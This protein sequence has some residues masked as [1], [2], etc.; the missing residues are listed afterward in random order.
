MQLRQECEL[1]LRGDWVPVAAE[2]SG[3]VLPLADLRVSVLSFEDDRYLIIDHAGQVADA[4]RW[5]LGAEASPATLDLEGNEGPNAGRRVLAI[6][7]IDGDRLCLGYDME[8]EQRPG[9]WRHEPDQL[10]LC[11]TYLRRR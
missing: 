8:R 4:G 11:I 2:V 3:Q 9:S 1:A 5:Q 6:V 7:A 10:L